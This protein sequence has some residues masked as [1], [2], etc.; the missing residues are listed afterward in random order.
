[1]VDRANIVKNIKTVNQAVANQN[2]PSRIVFTN[3]LSIFIGYH[4]K[5]YQTIKGA[6][7]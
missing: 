1:M 4:V 6:I 5:I 7:K 2:K 3:S